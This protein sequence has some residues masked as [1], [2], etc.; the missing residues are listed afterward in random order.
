[1]ANLAY[2]YSQ[3]RLYQPAEICYQTALESLRRA[4]KLTVIYDLWFVLMKHFS[5][6]FGCFLACFIFPKEIFGVSV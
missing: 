6:S 3:M 2:A 1:M 5:S 4:G